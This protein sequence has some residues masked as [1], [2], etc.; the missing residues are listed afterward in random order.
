[1]AFYVA[2]NDKPNSGLQVKF[3]KVVSDLTEL[4]F[5][6]HIAEYLQHQISQKSVQ[7][8]GRKDNTS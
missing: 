7:Q 8:C 2:R 5:S 3:L 1:M 4:G 6:R